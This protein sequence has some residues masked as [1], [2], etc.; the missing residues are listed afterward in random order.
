MQ[1]DRGTRGAVYRADSRVTRG[2][3][4][5][6]AYHGDARLQTFDKRHRPDVRGMDA[7][8][9]ERAEKCTWI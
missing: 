6:Q 9:D 4:P 8:F 2:L 1:V 7:V 5:N 3:V